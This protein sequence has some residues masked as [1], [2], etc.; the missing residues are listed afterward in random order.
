[1]RSGH[2]VYLCMTI[3]DWQYSMPVRD[4]PQNEFAAYLRFSLTAEGFNLDREITSYMGPAFIVFSQDT[5]E[6]VEA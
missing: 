4:M 3:S 5:L 1:M 6:P 2:M